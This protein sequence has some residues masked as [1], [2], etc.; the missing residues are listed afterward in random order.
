MEAD[1][2]RQSGIAFASRHALQAGPL[3]GVSLP[4]MLLSGVKLALGTAQAMRLLRAT[5]PQSILLTGGWANLPLA[6]GARC[7]GIPLVIYLPDI[8]P[9]LTIQVLRRFATRVAI[10]VDE[11]AKYFDAAKTVVTGYPLQRDRLAATRDAALNHFGLDGRRKVLLVFGGSRGAR[12][13]NMALA[14]CLERLLADGWQILH[15]TGEFDWGRTQRQV[16]ALA[17][18][19][20]YHAFA[21]LHDDMGLALAAA[22]LAVCRAG[23]SVLAEL[24]CFGLPGV[25]VP[26]PHA[27]RYQKVNADYLSERGAAL[28][29]ND[30]DMARQLYPTIKALLDDETR[31]AEMR[32][33]SRALATGDGARRLADL[34]LE[35]ARD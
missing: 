11:S 13:I 5:R 30:A 1:L 27:W 23:A 7:F 3:H 17:S 18:E 35:A 20:D 10:T 12:S 6:I 25:L 15:V 19:P 31:L 29:L 24:P 16:G 4:R 26:Y 2:A 8:E 22:D 34:L 33:R 21:Y 14:D 28:R 32:T 9:G